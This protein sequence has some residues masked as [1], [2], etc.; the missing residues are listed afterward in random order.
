MGDPPAIG[1][2]GHRH[3][4]HVVRGQI[5]GEAPGGGGVGLERVAVELDATGREGETLGVV[6]LVADPDNVEAE[7][8][9][10]VRKIGRAHV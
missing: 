4:V 3:L 6:R 9:I 5:A 10:I 8:A 1:R 2:R 7:F